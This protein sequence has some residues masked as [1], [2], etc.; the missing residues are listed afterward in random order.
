MFVRY[1]VSFHQMGYYDL[2]AMIDY[3]LMKTGQ[4]SLSFVG[5]SMGATI[6]Y[7]LLSLRP[8]YNS[9][10]KLLVSLAPVTSWKHKMNPMQAL[11]KQTGCRLQVKK[12]SAYLKSLLYEKSCG[13]CSYAH[14]MIFPNRKHFDAM[15]FTKFYP[16]LQLCR[17]K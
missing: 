15:A 6:A 4:K 11:F 17:K 16:E 10:M 12:K 5:H 2:P 1:A 14:G 3:I 7:V 8:E 9:K 13:D